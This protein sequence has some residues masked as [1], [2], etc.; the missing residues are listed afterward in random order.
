ME[1]GVLRDKFFYFWFFLGD[2]AIRWILLESTMRNSSPNAPDGRIP[3]KIRGLI[4]GWVVFRVVFGL[5]NILIMNSDRDSPDFESELLTWLIVII[6][7]SILFV[8]WDLFIAY[9]DKSFRKIYLRLLFLDLALGL[10][11]VGGWLI[12]SMT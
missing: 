11:V 5:W 12:I 9:F 2:L 4:V 3:L 1:T 10:A 6:I 8:A 7:K